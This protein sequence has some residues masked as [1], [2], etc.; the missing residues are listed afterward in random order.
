METTDL[1]DNTL[2]NKFMPTYRLRQIDRVRV[3]ASPEVAWRAIRYGNM[4]RDPFAQALFNIRLLP[5]IAKQVLHGEEPQLSNSM[6]VEQITEVGGG[7]Q[8]LGEEKDK[9]FVVGSIGQFWKPKIVFKLVK[10]SQFASFDEPGFGKLVWNIRIEPDQFGG[11]WVSVELRVSATNEKAWNSF[12]PYW[13]LIGPFSHMIRRRLLAS[14]R[15]ELGFVY[16]RNLK[17]PG[18]KIISNPKY[19]STIAKTIDAPPNAVWP[20]LVQMGCRRAGWYSIDLLDNAGKPSAEQIIPELQKIS[21]GDI[22]PATPKGEDGFAV[23]AIDPEKSLVLGSPSLLPFNEEH[24]K[25]EP[26]FQDTWTFVLEPIGDSATRLITRV[27]A[28]NEPSVALKAAS[29]LIRVAHQVMQ[30]AQL[31]NLRSRATRTT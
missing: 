28:T 16:E 17:L 10:D 11:S 2:I 6:T 20:W 23:L 9:E 29:P 15:H 30:R 12:R 1:N 3:A 22:L 19:D 26:P 31:R 5:E 14:L 18:D 8:L 21:V 13:L 4:N 27:R 7:F 25:E 24:A